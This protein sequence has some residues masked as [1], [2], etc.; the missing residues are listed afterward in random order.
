[1][2]LRR[3]KYKTSS[4]C[5]RLNLI[6]KHVFERNNDA[7]V[8]IN[9]QELHYQVESMITALYV[10]RYKRCKTVLVD[11]ADT[12]LIERVPTRCSSSFCC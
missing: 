1:M 9:S 3:F 7:L 11:F 2:I 5:F 6:R 10:N 12:K 8:Y 4:F